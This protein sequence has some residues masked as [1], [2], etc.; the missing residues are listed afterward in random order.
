[1]PALAIALSP[2]IHPRPFTLEDPLAVLSSWLR[3]DDQTRRDIRSGGTVVGTLDAHDPSQIVVFAAARIDVSPEQ[4]VE[5]VRDSPRLWRGQGIPVTGKFSTPIRVDDVTEMS[6]SDDDLQALRRCQ[7]GACEVKLAGAQMARIK[8]AVERAPAD[9]RAAALDA[10]RLVVMQAIETYRREGL[11]GLHAI[12]DHEAPI[13]RH[14]TFSRLMAAA[15][16]ARNVTPGL[17]QYLAHY[18]RLALPAGA[19]EQLHWLQTVLLPKPTI[20]VWHATIQR[21]P[22]LDVADVAVLSRQVLATHYVNG[23]LALTILT[24]AAPER[25]LV[26]VNWT[27]V[28]GL[29]GILSAIRRYFVE[30]RV[31]SAARKAF[32]TFKDRIERS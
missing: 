16:I 10:F 31:R 12:N 30:R 15:D 23:S 19:E 24:R 18:P 27:S 14:A 3:L 1:V 5:R 8:S 22:A 25:Y 9:W 21:R 17:A 2:D 32:E 13:D 4:F 20:Q 6:L 28:D 7:P 26:Y 29:D 11:S